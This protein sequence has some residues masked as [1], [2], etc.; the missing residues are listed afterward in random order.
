MP[1]PRLE[2]TDALR[3]KLPGEPPSHLQRDRAEAVEACRSDGG[4]L[5]EVHIYTFTA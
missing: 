4:R 3:A 1:T 2:G 5:W